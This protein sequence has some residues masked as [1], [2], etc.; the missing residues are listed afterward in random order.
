MSEKVEKMWCVWCTKK[1]SPSR[2]HDNFDNAHIEAQRI[3]EK[4]APA[5]VYVLETIGAVCS[6]VQMHNIE[7]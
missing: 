1:G 7:L 5:L 4:E 2:M 6:S 3:A